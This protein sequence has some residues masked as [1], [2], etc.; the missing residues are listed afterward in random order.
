M[1]PEANGRNQNDESRTSQ[2]QKE[3]KEV[4]DKIQ[5]CHF[6]RVC[7]KPSLRREF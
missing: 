1:E 2:A 5:T 7:L 3:V 4:K 6:P